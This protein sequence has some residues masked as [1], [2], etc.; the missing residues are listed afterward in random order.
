M[1]NINDSDRNLELIT[2]SVYNEFMKVSQEVFNFCDNKCT[3]EKFTFNFLL[4]LNTIINLMTR[5]LIK[6]TI[7]ILTKNNK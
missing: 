1:Y 3:R 6:I 2:L 7:Q 4:F 5:K